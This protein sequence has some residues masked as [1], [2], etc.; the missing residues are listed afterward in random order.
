[1]CVRVRACACAC[2]RALGAVVARENGGKAGTGRLMETGVPGI[3]E[4]DGD[5]RLGIG[6]WLFHGPEGVQCVRTRTVLVGQ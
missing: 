6:D 2:E 5:W 4:T 3:P 1:M